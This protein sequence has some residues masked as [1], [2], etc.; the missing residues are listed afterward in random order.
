MW[1]HFIAGALWH[2]LLF[3]FLGD[4]HILQ[5]SFPTSLPTVLCF[6]LVFSACTFFCVYNMCIFYN[7]TMHAMYTHVLYRLYFWGKKTVQCFEFFWAK[8]WLSLI[9]TEMCFGIIIL[10]RLNV[11]DLFLLVKIIFGMAKIRSFKWDL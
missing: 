5:K 2:E 8:I 4:R 3:S 7:M 9:F 11:F 1:W 6:H 10:V